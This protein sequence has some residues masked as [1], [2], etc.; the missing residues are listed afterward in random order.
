MV[1][2]RLLCTE[3]KELGKLQYYF[4]QEIDFI[5]IVVRIFFYVNVQLNNSKILAKKKHST[6][7]LSDIPQKEIN[8]IFDKS[9]DA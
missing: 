6:T 5:N 8:D 3:Y 9:L 7:F 1:V 2:I 4:C